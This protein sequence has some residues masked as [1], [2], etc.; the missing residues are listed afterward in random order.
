MRSNS[1][2]R[3]GV[4]HWRGCRRR[5]GSRGEDAGD[6]ACLFDVLQ[7]DGLQRRPCDGR[8]YDAL[9]CTPEKFVEQAYYTIL[10][11]MKESL[12]HCYDYLLADDPGRTP[13]GEKAESP[14]A[15]AEAFE[16]ESGNLAALAE[17]VRGA[18]RGKFEMLSCGVSRHEFRKDGKDFTVYLNT[19]GKTVRGL[20][21]GIALAP[22]E[23]R[24]VAP[25]VGAKEAG[26]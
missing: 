13:F 11:G 8:W 14:R 17:L 3:D 22:H 10:G 20:A 21:M 15:C 1:F 19:T 12:V 25:G 16:R 24:I 6:E 23:L 18:E 9:N 2:D 7:G 4:C 26:K 5:F